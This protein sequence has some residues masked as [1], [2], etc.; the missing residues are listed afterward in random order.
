MIPHGFAA[1][2]IPSRTTETVAPLMRSL[3]VASRDPRAGRNVGA[4]ARLWLRRRPAVKRHILLR[5]VREVGR[6]EEPDRHPRSR[7]ARM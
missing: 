1:Q 3:D 4:S 5:R 7:I 6:A 2:A